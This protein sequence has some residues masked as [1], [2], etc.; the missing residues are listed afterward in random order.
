MCT[1]DEC[2]PS[3]LPVH[4]GVLLIVMAFSPRYIDILIESKNISSLLMC[5]KT[6][7]R[8]DM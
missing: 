5:I 7:E 6:H 4:S 2:M 3:K 1:A 8:I